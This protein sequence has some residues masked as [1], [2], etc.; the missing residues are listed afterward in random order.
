MEGER[1]TFLG[2]SSVG[3]DD[4]DTFLLGED[5][6]PMPTYDLDG[7]CCQDN[8]MDAAGNADDAEAGDVGSYN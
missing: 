3:H 5:W 2:T 1:D 7:N 8:N 6:E 4:I